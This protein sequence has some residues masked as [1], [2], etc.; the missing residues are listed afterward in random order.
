[1]A[2]FSGCVAGVLG[3]T[4][5]MGFVCYVFAQFVSALAP[6]PVKMRAPCPLRWSITASFVLAD[7]EDGW[8]G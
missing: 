8:Q 3:Y 7:R 6:V 1:M 5:M 4:G 2:I